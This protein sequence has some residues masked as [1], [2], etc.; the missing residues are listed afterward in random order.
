M[1]YRRRENHGR[2]PPSSSYSKSPADSF[3]DLNFH[4]LAVRLGLADPS[5][6]HPPQLNDNPKTYIAN[7]PTEIL[8]QIFIHCIPTDQFIVP[9]AIQAPMSLTQ[10]CSHW[11]DVA[12]YTPDLWS[13]IHINYKDPVEDIPLTEAW[14][15]RSGTRPLSISLS[16]DFDER[17]QQHILDVLCRYSIRWKH[18]RF[19]FRH[20]FCPPMYHLDL[21]EN[22]VPELSTFEFHARDVSNINTSQI[23]RLLVTAPKLRELTWIDDLADTDMLLEL[24]LHQL[25]RLSLSMDHGTV[26]YVQLLHR[27]TNLEHIRI[28]RPLSPGQAPDT[29]LFL[30]KLS[31]LNI[32]HDLLPMLDHLILPALKDVRIYTDGGVADRHAQT[33]PFGAFGAHPYLQ[34]SQMYSVSHPSLHHNEDSNGATIPGTSVIP[35]D[36][37]DPTPLLSLIERSGCAISALSINAYANEDAVLACLRTLS[38]SLVKLSIEGPL[39]G[40][41]LFASL[42]IPNS[43]KERGDGRSVLCP[44]LRDLNL[45]T[46]IA[47]SPGVLTRMVQSRSEAGALCPETQP[48]LRLRLPDGHRDLEGLRE[49]EGS[50]FKLTVIQRAQKRSHTVGPSGSR[51]RAGLFFRRKPC[52]SR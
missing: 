8:S 50:A 6:L 21:A 30:S 10:V 51:T 5:L 11:R 34:H 14:L 13:S 46:S 41:K 19:N 37:W 25:A 39:V 42:T 12:F 44:I 9:S 16:V 22:A 7:L 52:A 17:P 18:V 49:I 4:D 33:V 45:E 1:V 15:A 27:C 35:T 23:T 48:A 3:L 47:S 28:T 26:D 38:R 24:P 2:T 43:G 20:L 40:D 29:P 31:S 36:F 32:P